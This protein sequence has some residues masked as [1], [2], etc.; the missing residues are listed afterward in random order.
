MYLQKSCQYHGGNFYEKDEHGEFYNGIVVFMVVGLRK[1]IP[2]VIK[3]LPETRIRGECLN[4]QIIESLCSLHTAGLYVRAVITDNHSVNVA[5]F[6]LLKKEF[7]PNNSDEDL[8]IFHPSEKISKVYLFHD[9]VRNNLLNAKR[10]LFPSFWFQGFSEDINFNGG[11]IGWHL[12]NCV[13]E[14]D[15]NLQANLRKAPKLTYETLHPGN[16]K[17]N[18]QLALNIFH[19]TT[20]AAISSY[21][22][23]KTPQILFDWSTLGG[24]FQIQNTSL[25]ATIE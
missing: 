17:Q 16:K 21:F 22:P 13:Y 23:E 8:F 25:I 7:S 6:S 15:S 4:P 14:R 24:I 10:F 3:T 12:F 19:E 1:S 9:S 5:A 18:V 2:Y 11:E 20:T